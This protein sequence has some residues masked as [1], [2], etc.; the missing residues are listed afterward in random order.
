MITSSQNT[1]NWPSEKKHPKKMQSKYDFSPI[2]IIRL[3][4]VLYL[5]LHVSFFMM[6]YAAIHDV[7][8]DLI[9]LLIFH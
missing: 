7:G 3:P 9:N 1:K 2:R 5:N 8:Y 6:Y 4:N